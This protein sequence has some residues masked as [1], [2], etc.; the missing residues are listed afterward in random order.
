MKL[1]KWPLRGRVRAVTYTFR[2]AVLQGEAT[3]SLESR[4]YPFTVVLER[5]MD[6]VRVRQAIALEAGAIASRVAESITTELLNAIEAER[7]A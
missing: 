1:I 3:T 4:T 6:P 5:A 2:L 7:I